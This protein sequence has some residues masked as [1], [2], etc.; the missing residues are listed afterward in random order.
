M[1]PLPGSKSAGSGEKAQVPVWI[2][3]LTI[4]FTYASVSAAD[5]RRQPCSV[6]A[7]VIEVVAASM[8]VLAA[9]ALAGELP[10]RAGG[11]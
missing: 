1:V 3:C 10:A 4:Y 9:L 8:A 11:L 6:E 5:W 7:G 2:K